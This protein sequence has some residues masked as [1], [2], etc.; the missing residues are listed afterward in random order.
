MK[1]DWMMPLV[2]MGFVVSFYLISINVEFFGEQNLWTM[3]LELGIAAILAFLV[4]RYF[5]NKELK[6]QIVINTEKKHRKEWIFYEIQRLLRE[7]GNSLPNREELENPDPYEISGL[8]PVERVIFAV[9]SIQNVKIIVGS[10]IEVLDIA[11]I[12]LIYRLASNIEKGFTITDSYVA[13]TTI[14][15]ELEKTITEII[16]MIDAKVKQE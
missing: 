13:S 8:N 1:F 12:Q 16:N 15:D 11:T 2:V 10:N 9:N 14:L 6:A 7:A 4:S 5:S 3:A